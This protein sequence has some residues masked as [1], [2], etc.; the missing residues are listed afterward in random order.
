MLGH[1]L[2]RGKGSEP[3]NNWF[4]TQVSFTLP[5]LSLA[6]LNTAQVGYLTFPILNYMHMPTLI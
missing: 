4:G 3:V 5:V 6:L 2:G 1:I